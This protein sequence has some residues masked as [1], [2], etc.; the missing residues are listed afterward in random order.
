MPL[1][2]FSTLIL[3]RRSRHNAGVYS[4]PVRPWYQRVATPEPSS[5]QHETICA[6]ILT[7]FCACSRASPLCEEQRVRECDP[8]ISLHAHASATKR[9][10]A[11]TL[12]S[13][14]PTL[15]PGDAGERKSDKAKF[16]GYVFTRSDAKR[17]VEI[18]DSV[19][20][21]EGS[22]GSGLE[23]GKGSEEGLA[24]LL[25]TNTHSVEKVANE[26]RQWLFGRGHAS[27]REERE[28]FGGGKGLGLVVTY[29]ASVVEGS[30]IVVGSSVSLEQVLQ[31]C[32]RHV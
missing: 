16:G 14:W 30:H 24:S 13:T 18:I 28:R 3:N 32:C 25:R 26:V 27:K 1:L 4:K 10:S 31:L 9:V 21:R 23:A 22:G 19:L 11:L 5:R 7:G 20:C 17:L 15:T 29:G 8:R 6:H 12:T 2:I